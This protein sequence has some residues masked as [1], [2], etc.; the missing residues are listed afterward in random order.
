MALTLS[1]TLF[2]CGP[3]TP[4][5]VGSPC[6]MLCEKQNSCA[7]GSGSDSIPCDA[8]CVY[9]GNY[10]P[11]LAPTPVCPSLAAQMTCVA[12]AVAMSCSAYQNAAFQ[13][14]ICPPLVGSPCLSDS[15]CQH[16]VATYRCDLSRPG[17]YCTAPCLSTDDC[18]VAG[19]E[20]CTPGKAPS[21]DPGASSNQSWC[22][23]EC[24]TDADCRS[25]QGYQCENINVTYQ[26]GICDSP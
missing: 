11:G 4:A 10:Y 26:I 20:V 19:P 17:G 24:G 5:P 9:G 23:M 1:S 7:M 22:L 21:F 16:F 13:C 15:D 14:P 2:G 6:K 3:G 18:S 8:V 12:A 25:G